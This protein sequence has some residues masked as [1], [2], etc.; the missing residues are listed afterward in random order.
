MRHAELHVRRNRLAHQG[1][2]RGHEFQIRTDLRAFI[3]GRAPD[4]SLCRSCFH[5]VM[6]RDYGDYDTAQTRR[7]RGLQVIE[8]D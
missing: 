3:S 2:H 1:P 4:A 7:R 8:I 5:K 6:A